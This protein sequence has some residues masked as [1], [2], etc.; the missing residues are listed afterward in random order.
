M[1]T[2]RDDTVFP[3]AILPGNLKKSSYNYRTEEAVKAKALINLLM[4]DR[5]F[6]ALY[7]SNNSK[8][9]AAAMEKLNE[10]HHHAYGDAQLVPRG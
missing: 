5:I 8:E 1:P 6:L 3:H 10:A 9:R 4:Q 2:V 7:R